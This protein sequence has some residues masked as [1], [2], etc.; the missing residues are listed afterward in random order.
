ML[1]IATP[2]L[3]LIP[4]EMQ[5]PRPDRMAMIYRLGKP[6]QVQSTTGSSFSSTSSGRPSADNSMV[7]PLGCRFSINLRG[8]TE[9]EHG[10]NKEY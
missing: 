2:R 10:R 1:T 5:N 9:N 4:K 3:H 8:D 7:S 6:K